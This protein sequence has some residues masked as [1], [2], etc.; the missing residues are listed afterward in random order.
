MS[1]VLVSTDFWKIIWLFICYVPLLV[2]NFVVLPFGAG[3][4]A[5]M[6][7]VYPGFFRAS[8]NCW[9]IFAKKGES[10][11]VKLKTETMGWKML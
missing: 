5:Q 8:K 10:E 9:N 7:W 6:Y 2:A 1:S 4:L 11:T 3:Q